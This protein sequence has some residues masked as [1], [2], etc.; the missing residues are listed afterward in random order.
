MNKVY[1]HNNFAHTAVRIA[2]IQL[3][4]RAALQLLGHRARQALQWKCAGGDDSDENLNIL[5]RTGLTAI[6]P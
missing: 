2:I 4:V 6:H 1:D 3:Q 5:K